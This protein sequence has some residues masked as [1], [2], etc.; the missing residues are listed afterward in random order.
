MPLVGKEDEPQEDKFEFD[1]AGQ[2]VGHISLDQA[3]VVALRYAR[4]NQDFYGGRYAR[5]ELAWEEIS[6]EEGEDYYRVKLSFRPAQRFRGEPGAELLAIDKTGSVELRQILSQPRET[7]RALAL[8]LSAAGL[9]VVAGAAIA[10][11]LSVSNP[12]APVA[13]PDDA[14]ASVL[15]TPQ[16]AASLVSP[17]GNVRVDLI[18]GSVAS[19]VEFSYRRVSPVGIPQLPAG[20]IPTTKVFDLSVSAQEAPVAGGF[21]FVKP[22]TLTIQ[23]SAQDAAL[24]GGLE[25]NVSIHHFKVGGV[26][27][28]ALPTKVDFAAATAL[29]QVDSLSLFAL[30]IKQS[31]PEAKLVAADQPLLPGGYAGQGI[32]DLGTPEEL[33]QGQIRTVTVEVA[34]KNP[35]AVSEVQFV[36]GADPTSRGIQLPGT[37]PGPG[38]ILNR[39]GDVPV[40][41]RMS[42]RLEAPA[43]VFSERGWVEQSLVEGSALWSWRI[44]PGKAF[45]DRRK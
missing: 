39:Y 17:D 20:F 43:F 11:F 35:L 37:R 21:S 24:S 22:V 38:T 16:D 45:R 4:D 32:A 30:A 8:G 14:A 42:A 5:R 15:V 41:R 1:S 25:S 36:V 10:V 28:T 12:P 27:W 3:R 33:G 34:L 29:A 23:L 7:R 26:G 13:A 44:T 18:E 31:R 6:A 9:A 2:V 19:P 40:Y